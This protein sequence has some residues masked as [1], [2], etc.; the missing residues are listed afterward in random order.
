MA[1]LFVTTYLTLL[2]TF[3]L[4]GECFRSINGHERVTTHEDNG[5]WWEREV[6]IVFLPESG[7]WDAGLARH[8]I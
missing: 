4:V 2:H 7:T 8:I 5:P 6:V 3:R 1:L